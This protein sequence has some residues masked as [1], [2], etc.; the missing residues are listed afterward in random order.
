MEGK[1]RVGSSSSS[2]FTS[3]LFGP[4]KPNSSS[5]NF[6]SIFSPPSKG[7]SRNI[8]SS[9]HGSLDQCKESAACNLSSS[10]YYG[11]QDVYSRTTHNQTY[12]TINKDQVRDDD[13]AKSLDACRGNW[14]QGSLYY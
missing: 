11:G 6:N 2:S 8:L 13:D 7:T 10:L 14:W 3:Q 9:N 5:A 4:K 1:R 12:P